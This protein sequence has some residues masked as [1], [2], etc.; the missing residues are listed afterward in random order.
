VTGRDASRAYGSPLLYFVRHGE[1]DWNRERRLQGQRDVPLN[2][3]GRKQAADCGAIL[4][5]LLLREQR[6]PEEFDFVSSPLSRARE[7]M[8]LLRAKLGLAP[9]QYR[10]DARLAELSFGEWE[11][12]TFAELRA[13]DPEI[14][15]IAAREQEKWSFVPPGGESY[16][17]LLLRVREWHA[18][19]AHDTIV[20]AHGGIARTLIAHLGIMRP[21]D[22]PRGDVDQGVVYEFAGRDL[23][24]H[25]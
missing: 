2:D 24:R 6:R 3:L 18:S 19:V 22:A 11:G 25:D 1:T 5:T 13:R 9:E 4:H 23:R 21:A 8:E 10:I 14:V 20:V 16:A 7:T 17:Q 12:L 15:T